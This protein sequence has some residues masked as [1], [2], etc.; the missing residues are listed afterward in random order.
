MTFRDKPA[1]FYDGETANSQNVLVD[2]IRNSESLIIKRGGERPLIWPFSRLRRMQDSTRDVLYLAGTDGEARL[3]LATRDDLNTVRS[4]VS[5]LDKTPPIGAQVPRLLFWS[6]GAVLA[7]VVLVFV[8]VPNLADQLARY[9]PVKQEQRLGEAA[10]R[11]VERYMTGSEGLWVCKAEPGQQAL[12][13]MSATVLSVREM[14]YPVSIQVVDHPMVNAFALPG[15]HVILMKGLL[16]ASES[17]DD[18]AAVLAHELAHV[19]HRD[20][21]RLTMRAAGTAGMLSLLF[22][23]ATGA[24]L[25][26]VVGEQLLNS[27]YS[28]QAEAEAAA[29]AIETLQRLNLS[30]EAMAVFF[31]RL[32]ENTHDHSNFFELISTHPA[33]ARRAE[34]A[35]AAFDETDWAALRS[36]CDA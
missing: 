26:T 18:I 22:G 31:D 2:L 6:A 30:P 36:I 34:A 19:A 3:I 25:I 12:E 1:R 9:V 14:P 13:T 28:R 16:V 24:T 11:Q 32:A 21:I 4:L 20:P 27:S 7:F 5:T 17:P 35:R 15:G 29:Y 10:L 33:L 8:L 23:D